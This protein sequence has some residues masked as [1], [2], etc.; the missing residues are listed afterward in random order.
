MKR[1]GHARSDAAFATSGPSWCPLPD[2]NRHLP[3]GSSDFKSDASTNSAKRACHGDQRLI[4]EFG[5]ALKS[6]RICA[7]R[8]EH[9]RWEGSVLLAPAGAELRALADD[10]G[11]C[12][13]PKG[14]REL[15]SSSSSAGVIRFA[16]ADSRKAQ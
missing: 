11:G 7:R 4:G 8:A 12:G 15:T 9:L 16:G 10:H 3:F 1:T 14:T 2:S 13:A 5:A 6:I